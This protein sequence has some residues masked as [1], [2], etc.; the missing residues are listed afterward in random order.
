MT[1]DEQY[2][3]A[4]FRVLDGEPGP[5][6]VNVMRAVTEG[7]RRHRRARLAGSAGVAAAVVAILATGWLAT[8][9]W[10]GGVPPQVAASGSG[11]P[12]PSPSGAPSGPPVCR[13]AQLPVPAGQPPKGIVS[14]ADPTGH[15][16]VGRT[17]PQAAEPTPVIW[18]DAHDPKTVAM[19]GVERGL[20]DINSHGVAVGGS[21]VNG[22]HVGWVVADGTVS[23][24]K[25]R[26]AQVVGIND[27]GMM[28]GTTADGPARWRSP[29]DDPVPLASAGAGWKAEARAID[30]DGTI[31][32]TAARGA[33]RVAVVWHPDGTLQRMP[34]PRGHDQVSNDYSGIAIRGGLVLGK[35]LYDWTGGKYI[36]GVVWNL[37]TGDVSSTPGF[38]QVVNPNGW[39]AG[40]PSLVAGGATVALPVPGPE[41]PRQTIVTSISD[42][43]TTLA[44]Q[45]GTTPLP[46]V[47]TCGRG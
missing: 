38:F 3:A 46:V 16:I 44:G 36:D 6:T 31:V 43:G 34:A 32:G 30:E 39:I 20:S 11:R 22:K 13:A 23:R 17:Y 27:A 14:G 9:G 26:E 29:T 12:D 19:P 33:E 24:V 42:A 15:Y 7:E 10:R 35:A 47:W 40:S 21:L 28:A 1:T 41:D 8:S 25:G 2:G 5:S 45:V 37:G 4:V 18:V